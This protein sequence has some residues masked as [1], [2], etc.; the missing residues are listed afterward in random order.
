[1]EEKDFSFVPVSDMALSDIDIVE[2]HKQL[3]KNNNYSEATTLLNN[4]NYSKGMRASI[5]N[6]I[7]N[8]IQTI[9]LYLL[10]SVT[11]PEDYYSLEEPS[12]DFMKNN[13]YKFWIKPI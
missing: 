3:L 12:S 5:F 13:G 1:M 9:G 4:N 11:D 7:I 10:N 2:Q 8:R 6:E